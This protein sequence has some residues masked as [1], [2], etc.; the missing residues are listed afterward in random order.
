MLVENINVCILLYASDAMFLP[1]KSYYLQW[2]LD[3]R[4]DVTGNTDVKINASKGKVN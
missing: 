4:Y 3:R 2:M 1:N